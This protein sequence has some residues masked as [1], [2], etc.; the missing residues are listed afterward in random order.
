MLRFNASYIFPQ[1]RLF[2]RKIALNQKLNALRQIFDSADL[3]RQFPWLALAALSANI[4]ALALPLAILQILDRVMI[5]QS[6]ETLFLLVLGVIAA[7]VLE[8]L[9]REASGL[10]TG[11][12]GARFELQTSVD[13]LKHLVQVPLQHFQKDEPG[14]HAERVLASAKVADFYSGNALLVLFDFPFSII[15]LILIFVIGGWLV[16]VPLVISVLFFLL[17]YR[18]G[19][20]MQSQVQQREVI[21]D[22]R[23]GFITE[24][25]A[26]I[27]TVKTQM[28]ES[29]MLRRYERLQQTNSE[30]NEALTQGDTATG[31]ISNTFRQVTM[32]CVVFFGSLIVMKGAM[33][34]GG[35]AACMLLSVRTLQPLRHGLMVWI[36]YQVFVAANDRLNAIVH[37]PH[38]PDD[39]KEMLGPV[40]ESL[41][42]RDVTL[43][44]ENGKLLFSHLNLSI[45]AGDFVAIQGESGS[46]KTSLLTVMNGMLRPS[47]GTVS[48]DGHDLQG[49]V[50]DSVYKQIA[51]LPQ[52]GSIVAGTILQNLT[53]FDDSLNDDALRLASRL[54]LDRFVATMKMGYETALGNGV[55]S[56]IPTGLRQIIV[57]ARALVRHPSVILFDEANTS[58]DMSADQLLR[59]YLAELKGQC[60]VVLVTPRPSLI[61]LAD[62]IYQ[63]ENNRLIELTGELSLHGFQQPA[64]LPPAPE[65]PSDVNDVGV[66]IRRQF[67]QESDFSICLQ[68][69]LQALKWRGQARELAQAMPHLLSTLDLSHLC[70]IMANLGL[71]PKHFRSN[72]VRLHPRLMPCLFVPDGRAAMVVHEVL[73]NGDLRVFDSASRSEKLVKPE[74]VSGTSY[75]FRPHDVQK[76]SSIAKKSWV[77][78]LL[79]RMRNNIALVF[80][81]SFV[82]GVLSLS[83]P[84][85][86][87]FIYDSVIPS[88]DL[89]MA[90]YMSIGVLTV[91]AVGYMLRTLSGRI[92]AFVSGRTDYVL[93]NYLFERV[94]SLPTSF[95]QGASISRQVGRL[96]DLSGLRNFIMGPLSLLIFELPSTVVLI[97]LIAV[98]NPYVLVVL[99]VMGALATGLGYWS[100]KSNDYAVTKISK[101]QQER[102]EFLNDTLTDMRTIRL[103]GAA[104]Y[105]VDRFREFSG[106]AIMT[107]FRNRELQARTSGISKVLSSAT[108]LLG[109]ATS[110]YLAILGQITSGTM[111][112]T[113]MILWRVTG[114]LERLFMTAT[115]LNHVWDNLEQIDRLMRLKGE[116]DI[117]VS[118][119]LRGDSKGNLSFSRV[120]FR[121]VSDA[122]PVLLG[123]S[124][125]AKPGQLLVFTG[126]VGSGKSSIF[127]LI[128]RTYSPQAG[129][130][131][132]DG[133]DIRQLTAYD[134]RSKLSY[135]PQHSELFYGSVM[136]N[137]LLV[138]P[139]AS[140]A[141]VQWAVEMAGL[142]ADVAA[143]PEGMNTRISSS[144]SDQLPHGFR[145]RLSLA[146]VM[147]KPAPVVLLDEPGAGMDREGE[148]ALLRCL[149]WL[150]GK[151]TVLMAS[152]RPA[153]MRLADAVIVMQQGSLVA[154][155]P[156]ESVKSK[157]FQDVAK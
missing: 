86:V 142:T 70:S 22:R 33:T 114:P 121:Y 25:L 157:I 143:L 23:L 4:L 93:G 3:K 117:G 113:M 30:L 140:D 146:R 108:G 37:L 88:G 65:R 77:G 107:N 75:V 101:M 28:L 145:Q 94:I 112:A 110:A 67:S 120:S 71:L 41:V 50:A 60:T 135:M 17:I 38:E 14:T 43:A 29:L 35:L 98:I 87:R 56:T 6:L 115:T 54:G 59:S 122:D 83:A 149:A 103:C 97:I 144:K 132:L 45:K 129:T 74:Q 118:Q 134:L 105:W 51:L 111:M 76:K 21:D 40:K 138:N 47:Q 53:M 26:G 141:E 156:F 11:W 7:L 100:R 44:F 32:I 8:V 90:S 81:L 119:T 133:A 55:A 27:H 19:N 39:G 52:S 2:F 1:A 154:M 116:A 123:V 96:R 15:F 12:L 153:H 89:L 84:L 91:M 31:N 61:S 49:F 42:L 66:V 109:L 130:I 131:R 137:L 99:L 78:Q 139:A 104:P 18:S 62:T 68:P 147:L 48:V 72:L 46:G 9:L 136:Q 58:L 79:W 127:Q 73:P 64:P 95:T 152:Q 10:A 16:L 85:Y 148:E 106:K 126:G 155:G 13:A 151:S 36:R 125:E 102:R 57:I 82:G 124:F 5:N 92:L 20:W 69:L 24:V 63:I 150:R 34:P 128:E 80:V